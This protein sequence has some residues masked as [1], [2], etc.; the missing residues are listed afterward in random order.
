MPSRW[1][2]LEVCDMVEPQA[3]HL[4]KPCSNDW[5]LCSGKTVRFFLSCR[6]MAA[7]C[8]GF[9]KGGMSRVN[10]F[11]PSCWVFI[12]RFHLLP[13]ACILLL[14]TLAA[15]PKRLPIS[16]VPRRCSTHSRYSFSACCCALGITSHSFVFL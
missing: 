11:S 16:M 6:S 14:T 12:V 10:V 3:Q 13:T 5:R 1:P 4:T 2:P 9:N 15:H 7:A 8:M